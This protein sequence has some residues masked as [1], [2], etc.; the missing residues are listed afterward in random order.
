LQTL[1]ST[2]VRYYSIPLPYYSR[3]HNIHA[4]QDCQGTVTL[5]AGEI[6]AIVIASFVFFGGII[7]IVLALK[8]I[9]PH[10]IPGKNGNRDKK[11]KPRKDSESNNPTPLSPSEPPTYEAATTLSSDQPHAQ[12]KFS[13]DHNE[14]QTEAF[15]QLSTT[16]QQQPSSGSSEQMGSSKSPDDT[17]KPKDTVKVD[18]GKSLQGTDASKSDLVAHEG[19]GKGDDSGN[20]YLIEGSICEDT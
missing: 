1:P 18:S 9:L 5:N 19:S 8:I 3:P 2:T 20:G 7:I 12:V 4:A 11:Y 14:K 10:L 15:N 17:E 16:S 13:A 6:A